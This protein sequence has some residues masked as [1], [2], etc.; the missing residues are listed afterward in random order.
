MSAITTAGRITILLGKQ[1][2]ATGERLSL[3]RLAARAGVPKDFV[4]RLD[5]GQARSINLEALVRLCEVLDCELGD[6]LIWEE[7]EE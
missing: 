3:R 4:Y 5:S 6:I 2:V 7:N 1:Q